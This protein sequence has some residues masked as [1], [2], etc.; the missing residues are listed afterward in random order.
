MVARKARPTN[1]GRVCLNKGSVKFSGL[2][3]PANQSQGTAVLAW[4]VV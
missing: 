2:Q 1:K 4:R 3:Y